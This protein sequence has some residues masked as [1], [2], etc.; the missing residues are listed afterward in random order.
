LNGSNR[1]NPIVPKKKNFNHG[2]DAVDIEVYI[3]VRDWKQWRSKLWA[4]RRSMPVQPGVGESC[5][6]MA[7]IEC[8]RLANLRLSLVSILPAEP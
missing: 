8:Q 2:L 5:W 7:C 4:C 3:P 1:W 6:E